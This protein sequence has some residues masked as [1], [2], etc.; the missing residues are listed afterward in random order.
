[1]NIK[2]MT[3]YENV[4]PFP[5][6]AADISEVE[7]LILSQFDE[8]PHQLKL[9]AKYILEHP[10]EVSFCSMREL[11]R[12]AEVAH[13][14]VMRLVHWLGYDTFGELRSQYRPVEARTAAP[15]HG[16]HQQNMDTE[17]DGF[18]ASFSVQAA[19]LVQGYGFPKAFVEASQILANASRV[20]CLGLSSQYAAAHQFT[21]ALRQI[22]KPSVLLSDADGIATDTLWDCGPSDALMVIG[23]APYA[24][25]VVDVVREAARRKVKIVA[26]TDDRLSPLA[27][28]AT[29]SILVSL[30]KHYYFQSMAPLSAAAEI[31]AGLVARRSNAKAGDPIELTLSRFGRGNFHSN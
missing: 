5:P 8:M 13:S 22:R 7:E 27:R 24:R 10:T 2:L 26:I 20:F 29:V 9:A 23:V 3:K 19:R 30:P 12:R 18:I 11:A 6:T 16:A 14:T 25:A 21:Y 1:M 31:L 15:P 28:L 4:P 17:L